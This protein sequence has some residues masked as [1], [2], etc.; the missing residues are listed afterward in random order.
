[1]SSNGPAGDAPGA[2]PESPRQR[3]WRPR[4][5][6]P[7][8]LRGP[9]DR[10]VKPPAVVRPPLPAVRGRPVPPPEAVAGDVVLTAD[11]A[12]ADLSVSSAARL[13]SRG[14]ALAGVVVV[15]GVVLSRLI[16]WLRT[17]VFLAQ[18]GDTSKPLDA[19]YAA[20]RIPDTLFQLV[21][22][23]AVGSA[24]VPVASAL[25]AGGEAD[26]ARRL[27]STIANLMVLALIPLAVVVWIAAPAIVPVIAKPK[28]PAQLDL[29]IGMTRVMLLSPMLLAV[30][31]VMTAGLNSL[32]IFGAPAM[33]PNVY[34]IGIIVCA[35]VL[36]PFLGIYAL[37]IGVVVGAIG[38]VLTQATAVRRAQLYKPELHVHDPAVL[39]TLKLMAPRALGLGVTQLVF[40]VNTYFAQSLGQDGGL[41]AYTAAFT[42]LQIPIGLIGVPLGIILLPPLSRAVAQGDDERFRRLVDQSLRLLLFAVVPLM[43]FMLVLA[44]PTIAF[45]YQHGSFTAQ[46]TAT[47][48][49]IYEV[50][51]LGLVAHVLIALMAPIFYAG[52]DTRTP[53]T[54]ALLAVAV[55]VGAAV[56][57][58]PFFH[59]AGLALAIGLGAWAEV[60]LL[61]AFM[62]RRIGFDLRPMARHAI[63]FAAGACVASAA[64]YLAARYAEGASGGPSSFLAQFLE[65]AIGGVVGM[66]VYVAW[67][68][69]FRL[70]ELG[71][72]VSLAKMLVG[73]KQAAQQEPPDD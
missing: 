28:D 60:I 15:A 59:L 39:E 35:V 8:R 50:F 31:A 7:E 19:F 16:G 68:G 52:K 36:T 3:G 57:L 63:S 5:L 49:P 22:A 73:R 32:G 14:I 33:A 43:G 17:A 47:Y 48:T 58:F 66:A 69:V 11:M 27:I 62:E 61:V 20:F 56:V 64:A 55:D 40:L 26:R 70:P 21:A 24:L 41:T 53:V 44:S 46:G 34:N 1:M 6:I 25:L 72:S 29:V 12:T 9:V 45:L 13:G 54:A 65:L 30:G 38:L 71:A 4:D 10:P 42:T 67:A 23:G 2:A 51:L 18:F 37:A